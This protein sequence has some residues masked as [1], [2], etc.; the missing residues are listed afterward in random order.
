V[1]QLKRVKLREACQLGT[2]EGAQFSLSRRVLEI[3]HGPGLFGGCSTEV[4][5]A[6]D[7]TAWTARLEAAN[8]RAMSFREAR[9][10]VDCRNLLGECVQWRHED[11]RVYWCDVYGRRL[12]RCDPSG[13]RLESWP[14]PEKMA[15]F[16]F[17][18]RGD[19]LCAFASGLFR[20]RLES[21]RCE[22]L[23]EFEPEL[24]A[25]RLNDGRCDRAGRFI[26]GGCHEG[27]YNPVSSVVSYEGGAAA[28][29]LI[30]DVALANGIAFSRNG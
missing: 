26:V 28:R 21:G 25:T 6:H 17:D 1:A 5:V 22:R 20:W 2:T 19:L 3:S 11:G 14:L 13:Q 29:T 23:T 12:F 7:E 30:T 8:V 18:A 27:F 15:S 9:L 4:A 10:L 24:A 16:T